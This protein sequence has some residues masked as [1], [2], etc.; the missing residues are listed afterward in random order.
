MKVLLRREPSPASTGPRQPPLFPSLW[1]FW[2]LALKSA[3]P[4]LSSPVPFPYEELLKSAVVNMATKSER[5][6][7]FNFFLHFFSVL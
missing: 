4:S 3:L 6:R 5:A 1:Q 2:Q 7:N